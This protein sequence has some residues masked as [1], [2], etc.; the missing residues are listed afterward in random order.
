MKADRVMVFLL[1]SCF[2]LDQSPYEVV[3]RTDP[4]PVDIGRI[5][6]WF[7][8]R[9]CQALVRR[10]FGPV[11]LREPWGSPARRSLIE[12]LYR[13]IEIIDFPIFRDETILQVLAWVRHVPNG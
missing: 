12:T 8:K 3:S 11:R 5:E 7:P 9:S 2:L 13:G 1:V 4:T 6:S 10:R